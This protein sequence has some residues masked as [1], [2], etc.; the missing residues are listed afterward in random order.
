MQPTSIFTSH[1]RRIAAPPISEQAGFNGYKSSATYGTL[2]F[3]EDSE[4]SINKIVVIFIL[5]KNRVIYKEFVSNF[6]DF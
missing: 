4:G 6:R 2:C 3:H 1:S 5:Q